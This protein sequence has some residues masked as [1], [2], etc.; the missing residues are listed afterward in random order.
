MSAEVLVLTGN[1][2][3]CEIESAHA[4]RAVG[5]DSVTIGTIWELM[6]GSLR[7]DRFNLLCLPG[8]FL[9]GD[10]L[11]SARAG[12]HRFAHG[13]PA[14]APP[15]M[16]QLRSLL[17]AGGL[18]IGICNGFQLLVKLGLLPGPDLEQRATLTRN[19]SS[20]FEDRWVTLGIN[21]DSPCVFTQGIDHIDLPVRHGEGR[22][23]FASREVQTRCEDGG[24]IPLVYVD[25][26]GNPTEHYPENP[27]GSPGGAAAMTDATGR[28][29]GLMPHPEA[30]SHRTNH[31]HWTRRDLPEE[32]AGLAIFRNGVRYLQE[33]PSH[34]K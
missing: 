28:I 25:A 24:L 3:N 31:P 20:R 9:D 34:G 15:L 6:E 10:H 21:P 17:D 33:K 23:V 27:N 5:A 32:G 19:L 30:F 1:G 26:H 12:A 29:F 8:G 18:V 16:T 22:L 2:T 11:G 4:F 14:G 13:H 7:L